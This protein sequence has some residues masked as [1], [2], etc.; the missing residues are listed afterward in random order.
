VRLAHQQGQEWRLI[1]N[2][3]QERDK[4]SVKAALHEGVISYALMNHSAHIEAVVYS[5]SAMYRIGFITS[6]AQ[7]HDLPP[8]GF[9]GDI[10]SLDEHFRL[11]PNE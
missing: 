6:F 9:H 10:R 4:T 3:R 8:T 7:K 2:D 11:K 5:G 1:L